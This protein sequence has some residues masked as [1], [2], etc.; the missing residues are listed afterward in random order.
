MPGKGPAL[1]VRQLEARGFEGRGGEGN[2]DRSLNTWVE[3]LEGGPYGT[4]DLAGGR[5]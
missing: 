5:G 1:L 3:G 2:P 4:A